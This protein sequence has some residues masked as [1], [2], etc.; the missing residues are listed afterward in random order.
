MNMP[1]AAA[2]RVPPQSLEAERAALG[3]MLLGSEASREAIAKA[4]A[5]LGV[6]DF[7]RA[8]HQHVYRTI[9]G[10]FEQGEKVDLV[11]VIDHLQKAGAVDQAGG[12][13]AI[14]SLLDEMPLVSN[15]EE[16][17]RIIRDK[18]MMRQLMEVG[19][20]LFGRAADDAMQVEDL[21]NNASQLLYD[22][23]QRR[24]AGGMHPMSELVLP[25]IEKIEKLAERGGEAGMLTGLPTGFHWLDQ[26]TSGLQN[27]ELNVVA[28]R[29]GMGKTSFALNIAEHVAQQKKV[30]VLVFSMEMSAHSLVRRLLCAHA[31]VDSQSVRRGNPYPE[32]RAKLF[33]AASVLHE[34]PIW[35]DESSRLTPLELRARARRVLGE[36]RATEGQ[37]LIIVDYLQLMDYN[38][39]GFAQRPENRQQEITAISRSMKAVAKELN[40]PVIVLSQLSRAPERR[41]V[42]KP[43][44]SDLRESGAI[45]QDADV[46][47]FIYRDPKDAP[48]GGSDAE[49][50][51]YVARVSVA[52]QRNGPT[53]T[54]PL[55]FNR[56]YTRFD[57]IESAQLLPDDE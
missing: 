35:I 5:I 18:A 15:I 4:V 54:F 37:G 39:E 33:Q 1:R 30:P 8:A 17:A 43:R 23:S 9:R 49:Q 46:V 3:A 10:L 56:A 26:L 14:A 44:L 32:D 41:E 52:K 24:F 48:E 25:E 50:Q 36:T 2:E 12:K 19:S 51:S 34:L 11:T 22:I 31:R 16:Y 6:Q 57:Q 38:A 40:V 28:A 29:P 45:E 42:N 47:T 55:L 7:Y 53:G 20:N 21:L 27:G 13:A